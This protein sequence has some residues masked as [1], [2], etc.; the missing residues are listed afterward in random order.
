[1]WGGKEAQSN[2]L[3]EKTGLTVKEIA[4]FNSL[5]ITTSLSKED[6]TNIP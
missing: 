6:K 1:M 4:L 5:K 3:I 2:I